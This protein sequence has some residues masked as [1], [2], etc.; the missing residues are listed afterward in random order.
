[1]LCQT[2]A[3]STAAHS[4]GCCVGGNIKDLQTELLVCTERHPGLHPV[5]S[6][7]LH[8]ERWAGCC[9]VSTTGAPH[10]LLLGTPGE[11]LQYCVCTGKEGLG[12]VSVEHRRTACYVSVAMCQTGPCSWVD[13]MCGS[14]ALR[15]MQPSHLNGR[16]RRPK[17]IAESG[18]RD[19]KKRS[20]NA[21]C[22]LCALRCRLQG[23]YGE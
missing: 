4:K 17:H 11:V 2:A 23:S 14:G 13:G 21:H 1:V 9:A 6:E 16:L 10:T 20:T 12:M 5:S 15:S 7:Q 3:H 19:K 22:L 8:L 18:D